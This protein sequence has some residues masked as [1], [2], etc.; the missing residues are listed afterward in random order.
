MF[1]YCCP[2]SC[3]NNT[4]R[5]YVVTKWSIAKAAP[6]YSTHKRNGVSRINKR[7]SCAYERRWTE[8]ERRRRAVAPVAAMR[9][10]ASAAVSQET[11]VPGELTSGSARQ[12]VPPAQ[13]W[14]TITPLTH[15]A[16]S[17]P[18]HDGVVSVHASPALTVAN[19]ALSAI[20]VWP[21]ADAPEPAEVDVAAA[22]ESVE[23]AAA[24]ASVD[25]AAASVEE[26]AASVEEAASA[27]EETAAPPAPALSVP[28]VTV[29]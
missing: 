20:A 22:A 27:V 12:T 13:G 5:D 7:S 8:K 11:V 17:S 28:S 1:L 10:A 24:A 29:N 18:A 6:C 21:S 26:A 25:E 9:A 2:N 15:C 4:T 16:K 23:E 3:L 19:F 14:A